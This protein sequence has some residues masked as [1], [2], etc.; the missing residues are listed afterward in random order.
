MSIS[1]SVCRSVRAPHALLV[2][3]L[4][5]P[6]SAIFAV[7]TEKF[8]NDTYADFAEGEARGVAINT[9]GFLKLGPSMNKWCSLSPSVIWAVI[10]DSK[11]ILYVA[12]GNEGQVFKIGPDG[13]AAEFFKAAE[14]QVQSLALD[15]AGDLFAGSAPDGKVYRIDSKGKSSLFFDPKEKYIWAMQF[16]PRG[17][18]FVATGDKGKLYK[19]TA[20]GKGRVYYD[21]DETH[22]R[23]LLFDGRNRLWAGSEGTGLV[24]RFDHPDGASSTPFVAY[25]SSFREIKALVA[26]PDDSLFVA[27][28]GDGKSAPTSISAGPK[29]TLAVTGATTAAAAIHAAVGGA[30]GEPKVEEVSFDTAGGSEKPGAGEI[31]R[32]LASGAIEKWWSDSEDV[33]S[34]GMTAPGRIWAGTGKH[35]RLLE[36][37]GP[38]QFSVLGQLEAET[39]TCLIPSPGEGWLAASSNGGA[40]WKITRTPG[41][42]GT[43]ESKTLDSRGSS[44]WGVLDVRRQSATGKVGVETRCGNTAK[45]DKVW[46]DWIPLDKE[47]RVQSPVARY[48]Q[49][50]LTLETD[51]G[52]AADEPAVDG[53]TFFYQPGNQPPRITRVSVLPPNFEIVKPPR[54]EL[55]P[56]QIN[57]GYG[58][59]SPRSAKSAAPANPDDAMPALARAPNLQPVK[60]LGWRSVLWQANDPN[61]D[62]LRYAVHHRQAG[63]PDWKLLRED[64]SDPFFAWDAARWPDGDYYL[65]IIAS[66]HSNN[67]KGQARTDEMTSELF[68]IDNTAPTIEIDAAADAIRKGALTVAIRDTTSIVDEAQYSVDGEEWRPLL[69]EGEIYDTKSNRFRVP[70]GN[71]G[72]GEHHVV[73]R[74]SDSANNVATQSAR[75]RK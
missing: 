6:V 48:V 67:A 17:N 50:R 70:L 24:Y 27:A 2:L 46:S 26:G 34:L 54:M 47:R 56:M 9:D 49:Y 43:Y 4:A 30:E 11:G 19:I 74:A 3:L 12:A 51:P 39:I 23:T 1:R 35:G 44:R 20:S 59:A 64:L 25:D 73:I 37:T 53:V 66:D 68:T 61:N 10:R 22:L 28:M 33:Y 31:L 60:K 18:L 65:K 42:K 32:I 57:P 72:A 62:E 8:V 69:P 45:P 15:S 5:F 13:K 55:P 7:Q 75:F 71:L 29:L 63:S 58:G 41:R 38:K 14:L 52:A 16:D 36:I 21:S 40:L